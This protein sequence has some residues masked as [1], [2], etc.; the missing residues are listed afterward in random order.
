MIYIDRFVDYG[1][2]EA[3]TFGRLT[4]KRFTCYTVEPTWADNQPRVSCIP[5]GQYSLERHQSP[6]FGDSA[7][8][9]GGT[10]SK[11]PTPGF[12]RSFILIHPAN[13]SSQLEGCIGLGNT[14]GKL[15]GVTSVL[16]SRVTVA[17]F[18]S[19]LSPEKTYQLSI[20]YLDY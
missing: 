18:L 12:M 10:V 17:K 6:K 15:D 9:Y 20:E 19:L 8:I 1:T 3:G 14:L 4:Y 16:N 11:F 7:I 13:K 5:T 2:K